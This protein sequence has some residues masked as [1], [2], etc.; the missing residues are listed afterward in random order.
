MKSEMM[1]PPHILAFSCGGNL[2]GEGAGEE[3]QG[4]RSEGEHTL[5]K[6]LTPFIY[7]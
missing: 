2:F 4:Y 3:K 5:L 6:P 7:S 1:A